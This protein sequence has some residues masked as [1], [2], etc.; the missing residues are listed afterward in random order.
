M[1]DALKDAGKPFELVT[2]QGED[3][4]LSLSSTRLQMLEAAVGFVE[5]HNPAD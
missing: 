1:A 3:H 2:L 5:K 4:W